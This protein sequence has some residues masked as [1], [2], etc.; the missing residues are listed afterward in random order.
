MNDQEL[1]KE[2]FSRMHASDDTLA[3]VLKMA[4]QGKRG[5]HFIRKSSAV[6]A[7]AA[8]TGTVVMAA[9]VHQWSRGMQHQLQGTTEQMQEL[10][11]KNIAAF[12]EQS[13]TDEGVTV[14]VVQSIVNGSWG[15]IALKVSGYDLPDGK[16][17][18]FDE[19]D[20][21][22]EGWEGSF[23]IGSSFDDG[24]L[25][26]G[27]RVIG[28][29][30]GAPETEED[31]SLAFKWEDENGDLEYLFDIYINDEPGK[32]QPSLSGQEVKIHLEGLGYYKGK[33]EDCLVQIPGTW[34]FAFTLPGADEVRKY[35]DLDCPI[36]DSGAVLKELEVSPISIAVTYAFPRNILTETGYY[37]EMIT[38]EDG[39]QHPQST[40]FEREYYEEPPLLTGVK[41]KDGTVLM[42]INGGP[43]SSG[44]VDEDSG[45]WVNRFGTGK[46]LDPD[47]IASLLFLDRNT[48][49]EEEVPDITEE[50]CFEVS[51]R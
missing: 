15:H 40:P 41:L 31:G 14:S 13:V 3:E 51:I 28:P 25:T 11:D 2:T 7:A 18:G 24:L 23:G 37:E 44:Y 1:L 26:N 6:I 4:E 34:D 5:K 38:E 48:L 47:E 9:T 32:E 10:E 30:G 29:D 46:I 19:A 22:I 35:T 33:A 39:T 17:P 16:E 43:G 21:S 20:L 27:Y 12:P 8:V 50:N 49:P 45:I 42:G 36:G